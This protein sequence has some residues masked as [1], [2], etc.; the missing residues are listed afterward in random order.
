MKILYT[1]QGMMTEARYRQLKESGMAI[2]ALGE[3]GAIEGVIEG[4]PSTRRAAKDAAIDASIADFSDEDESEYLSPLDDEEFSSNLFPG[5]FDDNDFNPFTDEID[6]DDSGYDYDYDFSQ[7]WS[8]EDRVRSEEDRVNRLSPGMD[9]ARDLDDPNF[10][11]DEPAEDAIFIDGTALDQSVQDAINQARE[12][13]KGPDKNFEPSEDD[14]P[15][16]FSEEEWFLES[17]VE[18]SRLM[19]K[20]KAVLEVCNSEIQK[21]EL[22]HSQTGFADM[23]PS[24][25][26]EEVKEVAPPGMEDVVLSLKKKFG[27]K[28]PRPYQIA[29]SMYN[30]KQGKKTKKKVNEQSS[31]P[32]VSEAIAVLRRLR[33]GNFSLT[34]NWE[35]F[36]EKLNLPSVQDELKLVRQM[37]RNLDNLQQELQLTKNLT[38]VK[39]RAARLIANNPH[40]ATFIPVELGGKF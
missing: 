23:S 11:G 10:F 40:I 35:S 12:M 15:Y 25:V 9:E 16:K 6:S 5:P 37:E 28:S 1:T 24:V 8:E 27:E 14:L 20:I 13:D 17:K 36:V 19:E 30:K 18:D 39:T 33:E 4:G 26:S 7:E 31:E 3:S 21:E 34:R 2:E 32:E 29:W 22:Q 38:K